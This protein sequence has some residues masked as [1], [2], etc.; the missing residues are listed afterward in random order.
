LPQQRTQLLSKDHNFKD[1]KS[2]AD[3][4]KTF[5]FGNTKILNFILRKLNGESNIYGKASLYFAFGTTLRVQYSVNQR[6][7]F[8]IEAAKKCHLHYDPWNG[9]DNLVQGKNDILQGSPVLEEL[10]GIKAGSEL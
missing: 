4:A 6:I 10:N 1:I 7:D 8:H 3:F 5:L 9:N 2:P